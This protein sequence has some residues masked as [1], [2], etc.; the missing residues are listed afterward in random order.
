MRPLG[1]RAYTLL[2]DISILFCNDRRDVP[3]SE[4]MVKSSR[5]RLVDSGLKIDSPAIGHSQ[6]MYR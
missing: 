1:H 2:P 5:I 4:A 6:A 3:G